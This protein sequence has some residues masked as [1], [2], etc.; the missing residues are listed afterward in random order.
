[1]EADDSDS[2]GADGKA[3]AAPAFG[4][5]RERIGARLGAARTAAGVE[6]A[7]I[8]KDTR[9][10]LRH[11]R[12]IEADAHD[13]LPALPYSIGFVKAYA[14]A[15]GIDADEA[16]TQFRGETSKTAHVPATVALEPLDERRL[17]SRG[18]VTLSVALL[19]LVIG[20]LTAYGA[21]WFE[22][23]P[24]VET[25]QAPVEPAVVEPAVT[26]PAS[27]ATPAAAG[28]DGTPVAVAEAPVAAPAT[29][30]AVSVV[31]K[32]DAWVR[33]TA[34]SPETGKLISVRTGLL[35]KGERFDL[36]AIPGQRLWT[37]R[38]GALAIS[39][40]GRAVPPLG[41]PVETVKNVSLDPTDLAARIAP[42]AAPAAST[43]QVQ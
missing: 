33:I 9:V 22:A 6:L 40:G 17:P 20:G 43:P 19:I 3:F 32:D 4:G 35:A 5:A 38:A 26:D 2:R 21:G 36:P 42:A 18:L 30:G 11:L 12:A 16:A 41:G 34:I 15:V 28:I 13:D 39:V 27:P 7:D 29:P 31:A 10:P 14:R 23:S 24:A 1:M 37:G 8:A 25:A